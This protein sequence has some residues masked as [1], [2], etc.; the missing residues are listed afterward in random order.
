MRCDGV[1]NRRGGGAPRGA[2]VQAARTACGMVPRY[3]QGCCQGSSDFQHDIN[4][5][6]GQVRA[7]PRA[8]CRAADTGRRPP[9]LSSLSVDLFELSS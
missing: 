9:L 6:G 7:K 2:H 4:W 3:F 8:G 1:R 5:V